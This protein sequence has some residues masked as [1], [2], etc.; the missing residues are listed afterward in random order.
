MKKQQKYYTKKSIKKNSAMETGKDLPINKRKR[1]KD[2]QIWLY[3]IHAAEAAIHNPQR[4]IKT[5]LAT[6]QALTKIKF[7][8][9]L[10]IDKHRIKIVD[11]ETIDSTVGAEKVHQGIAVETDKLSPPELED[12]SEINETEGSCL[13]VAIDQV[14]DPRNVGAIMRSCSAFGAK[15]IVAGK[16]NAP[17]ESGVLAKSASGAFELVPLI[18]VTNLKRSIEQLKKTDFWSVGLDVNATDDLDRIQMPTRCVLVLGAEGKGMRTGVQG[19]C[20]LIC[21]LPMTAE[22]NSLNVSNAGAIAMFEWFRQSRL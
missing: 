15:A 10:K 3:G 9:E 7:Y 11:K 5:I 8:N 13:I 20:D 14:T 21:K 16:H 18:K 22:T 4:K 2:R 1:S 19:S 17:D 12:I 6:A